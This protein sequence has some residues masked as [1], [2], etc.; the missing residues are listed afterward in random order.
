MEY[1]IYDIIYDSLGDAYA[2]AVVAASS[3]KRAQSLLEE[4]LK[5]DESIAA[6]FRGA[7]I[8][9]RTF[10]DTKFKADEEGVITTKVRI[11][12]ISKP[13]ILKNLAKQ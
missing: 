11:Q 2:Q 4:H 10:R 12:D 5:K 9:V 1:S 13:L 6:V 3:R 7:P 8:K